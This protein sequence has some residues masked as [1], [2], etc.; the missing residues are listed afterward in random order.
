MITNKLW[1]I[2]KLTIDDEATN[3]DNIKATA[4]SY[5]R[6]PAQIRKWK[7]MITNYVHP[8]K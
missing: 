2:R 3:A 7:L 6:F 1:L 4:Q 5:K 8:L